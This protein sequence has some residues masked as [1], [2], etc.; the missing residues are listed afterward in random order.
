VVDWPGSEQS[1]IFAG[2]VAPPRGMPDD[3][4]LDALNTLFGDD[5]SSRINMNLREDENLSCGAR[6]AL[7]DAAGERPFY[8]FAP[9]QTDK[10][11]SMNGHRGHTPA[12]VR[13]PQC[14]STAREHLAAMEELDRLQVVTRIAERPLSRRR[15]VHAGRIVIPD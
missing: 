10:T 2:Q 13:R 4:A 15:A 5:F 11:R 14:Y 6:S 7:V 12:Q 1:M 3:V 9:V 8:V